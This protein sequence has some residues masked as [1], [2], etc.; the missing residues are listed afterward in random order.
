MITTLYILSTLWSDVSTFLMVIIV[1]VLR[2]SSLLMLSS[3]VACCIYVILLF[4]PSHGKP[5]SRRSEDWRE[6]ESLLPG[7]WRCCVLRLWNLIN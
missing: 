6:L 2:M 3:M 5:E 7:E 4:L 1:P